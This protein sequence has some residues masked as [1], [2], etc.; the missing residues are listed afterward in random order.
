VDELTGLPTNKDLPDYLGDAGTPATLG[1]VLVDVDGLRWM[2]DTHGHLEVDAL[3]V[4]IARWLDGHARREN[5]RVFRVAGEEFLLLLPGRDVPTAYAKAKELV[6]ECPTLKLPYGRHD[7][8]RSIAAVSA[9]AFAAAAD[10]ASELPG[11]LEKVAHRIQVIKG[12]EDRR[13]SVAAVLLDY[14]S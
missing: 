6:A 2:N 14:Q 11:I 7:G 1:A 4:K 5:G 10:L 9:I 3:L 13:Y 8:S 12:V